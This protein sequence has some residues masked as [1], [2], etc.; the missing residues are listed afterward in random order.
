[1]KRTIDEVWLRNLTLVTVVTMN[2]KEPRN[3]EEAKKILQQCDQA[4]KQPLSVGWSRM[5]QVAPAGLWQIQ[6]QS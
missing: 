1:M 3:L 4:L 5:G 2:H 6:T